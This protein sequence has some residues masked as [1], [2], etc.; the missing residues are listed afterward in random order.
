V[1]AKNEEEPDP[2]REPFRARRQGCA[3]GGENQG[4]DAVAG[5]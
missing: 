1:R 3:A 2:D 5:G 4:R